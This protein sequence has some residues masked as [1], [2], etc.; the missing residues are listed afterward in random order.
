MPLT[1]Q[2]AYISGQ[3]ISIAIGNAIT[4]PTVVIIPAQEVY[5]DNQPIGGRNGKWIQSFSYYAQFGGGSVFPTSFVFSDLTGVAGD[6]LN[7]LPASTT[8]VDCPELV[9]VGGSLASGAG[10]NGYPYLTTLNYPKL[11]VVGNTIAGFSSASVLTTFNMPELLFAGS[12]GNSYSALSSLSLPKLKVINSFAGGS[13]VSLAVATSVDLSSIVYIGSGLG[14]NAPNCTTLTLPTLGTW[15]VLNGNFT[16]TSCAFNQT[17]VDNIL[18]ALA[19]MDGANSTLLFSGSSVR[20]ATITGTSSA[21][22]NLGSTTQAGS[23]FVGAGITCTVNWTSHGYAT[24][25]VLRISGITTLTNANRYARITVVNPNQFTYTITSQTATGAGTA[26]VIKAGAS[27]KALVT[28]GV[29][30]TTN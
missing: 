6:L 28:R 30:L 18:A 13:S 17:T 2:S 24:D 12:L 26:T 22:T 20:T 29:T 1:K 27:A 3:P 16:A 9:Y 23:S 11:K 19:Y 10:P 5:F 14:F 15:K 21:P 25:D 4:I 8:N 7:S